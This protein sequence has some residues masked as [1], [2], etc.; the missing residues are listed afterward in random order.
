MAAWLGEKRKEKQLRC[1]SHMGML[2]H[3]ANEAQIQKDSHSFAKK[4]FIPRAFLPKVQRPA[5][6]RFGGGGGCGGGRGVV[7]RGIEAGKRKKGYL[8]VLT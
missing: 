2:K 7:M 6:R 3:C 4:A 5:T 1:S 8:T